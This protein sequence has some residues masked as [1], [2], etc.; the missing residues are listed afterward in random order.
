MSNE[1]TVYTLH[2]FVE[3]AHK[4]GRIFMICFIAYS[5]AIPVVISAAFNAWPSLP[6]I[7]PALLTLLAMLGVQGVLEAALYT[8]IL[9][10][11]CYLTFAT[12][13][14]MNLKV[15]CAL[16]AQKVAGVETNTT[17]GDAIALI[18]TCVSSIVTTI[19]LFLGM[20]L[21]IP[22]K[23]FLESQIASS[24]SNY[25]M[26]AL[27]GCLVLAFIA[28]SGGKTDIKNKLW[29]G[30]IPFVLTAALAIAGVLETS[31]AVAMV[32]VAIPVCL[33]TARILYKKGVV[34]VVTKE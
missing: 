15:P 12:G 24:A 19:I 14:I 23:P 33:I 3:W 22:L 9:G 5:I 17:A 7:L 31:A 26:A 13:N 11:S 1:K 4:T 16:N 34:R 10:S 27:F 20:F 21:V 18:S 2:P 30:I 32:L 29:I 8:P 28:P 6:D 25:L